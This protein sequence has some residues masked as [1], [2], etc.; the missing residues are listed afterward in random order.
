M[1]IFSLRASNLPQSI[2]VW[3][4]IAVDLL[5]M[6]KNSSAREVHSEQRAP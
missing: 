6:H 1:V 4:G 5:A 3:T 2:P